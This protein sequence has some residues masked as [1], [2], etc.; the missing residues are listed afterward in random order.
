MISWYAP[1]ARAIIALLVAV[2]VTFS[3]NHS[4]V[5]GLVLFGTFAVTS[6]VVIA[7]FALRGSA[8]FVRTLQL[9]QGIS[10]I[11][12]GVI[13]LA[14]TSAGLPFLILI[15]A[16]FAVITGF[17]ELILGVRSLRSVRVA[18]DWIF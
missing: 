8:S 16:A 2:V 14:M 3:A 5:L 12:A 9:A 7:G 13:A 17:L 1:L 15:V 18:R 4:P 11:V 10:A 6:G